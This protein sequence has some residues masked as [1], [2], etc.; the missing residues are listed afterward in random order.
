MK[1][2]LK[3]LVS[4]TDPVRGVSV[5]TEY[6][7]ARILQMLQDTG[8]FASWIFCGG[9]AL[10]FLFELPRYS[11]D[12]DFAASSPD[13]DCDFRRRL[14]KVARAL[15]DEAYPVRLA[16][17]DDKTVRSAWLR[18]DGL[19]HELGLSPHP[20]QVLAVKVELDAN[21]PPAATRPRRSSEGTSC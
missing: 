5:A 8:A 1:D 6:C 19:P 20:D 12:L 7:Q 10:R 17:N 15:A 18:F 3:S 11:E 9:T 13:T 4:A 21:P 2:Y 14:E 16:C